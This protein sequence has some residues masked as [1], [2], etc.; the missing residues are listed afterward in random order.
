MLERV[1]DPGDPTHDHSAVVDERIAEMATRVEAMAAFTEALASGGT[2]A[3]DDRDLRE[4]LAEDVSRVQRVHPDAEITLEDVPDVAVR[5]DDRLPLLFETLLR[6]TVERDDA[7]LATVRVTGRQG[8]DRVVV[9]ITADRPGVAERSGSAGGGADD[10]AGIGY[11]RQF[12]T[13]TVEEY[14]GEVSVEERDP[15]GTVVTVVLP[16]SDPA[17]GT[18]GSARSRTDRPPRFPRIPVPA[19]GSLPLDRRSAGHGPV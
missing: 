7:V 17:R 1:D 16:R 2:R 14:G 9:S 15:H 18:P 12:V 11:G 5:A 3:L 6:D 8:N 13:R 10:P 4:T 19:F